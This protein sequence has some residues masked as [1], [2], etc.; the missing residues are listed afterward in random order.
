MGTRIAS[1]TGIVDVK[2]R[3]AMTPPSRLEGISVAFG[4]EHQQQT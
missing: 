2:I 1:G 3:V 4:E